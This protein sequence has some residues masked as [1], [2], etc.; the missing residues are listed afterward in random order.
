MSSKILKVQ[1]KII[2][3]V[4]ALLSLLL[5]LFVLITFIC[6]ATAAESIEIININEFN[7]GEFNGNKWLE[8]NINLSANEK[9]R[10]GK[11][12]YKLLP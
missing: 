6:P 10:T 2:D 1:N 7:T 4:T 12:C 3:K 9:N 8:E 5:F 11:L